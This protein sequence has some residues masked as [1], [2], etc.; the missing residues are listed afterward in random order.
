[1]EELEISISTNDCIKQSYLHYILR[2]E[3]NAFVQ[4]ADAKGINTMFKTNKRTQAPLLLL[5]KKRQ[6]SKTQTNE[7]A[8]NTEP[9][10]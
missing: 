9:M 10:P 4:D 2:N 3:Q 6:N 1:M 8:K 5:G 7:S